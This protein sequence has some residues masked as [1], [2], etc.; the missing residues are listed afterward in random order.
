M[1]TIFSDSLSKELITQIIINEH[2]A[3]PKYE[4]M[5][6]ADKYLANENQEIESKTRDFYDK[7]GNAHNNPSAY[8]AKLSSG[9]LAELVKQKQDYALAKTFVLKIKKDDEELDIDNEYVRAWMDF[10]HKKL[11]SFAYILCGEAINH[12]IAWC[13][14]WIDEDG[15]L[16]LYN[17][18]G[19]IVFAVWQDRNHTKLDRLVYNYTTKTYKSLNP[20]IDEY[21]EYWDKDNRILFQVNDGYSEKSEIDADGNPIHSQMM[22]GNEP[23]SWGRIPFVALK[24]TDDEKPLLKNIKSFIDAYDQ[25]GSKAVDGLIDDTD[26]LLVF[27]GISPSVDDLIEARELAKMT[28]TISLDTDGDAYYIQAQTD[29][30]STL[31]E[32]QDLRRDIYKFGCG[33]DYEDLRF[34]GNP[35]QM[36]IKSL[37]QSLDTYIDGLE[38]HFQNFIDNLKYFFDKWLEWSNKGNFEEMNSCNVL[39]KFDR[40]VVINR[41]EMINDTVKLAG[42]GVS[43]KTLMEF[44]PVVQDVE[45]E[46]DRVE[47]ERKA[48]SEN[49]LFNFMQKTENEHNLEEEE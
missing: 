33:V 3:D 23:I 9:F 42:T 11:F 38:R 7:D 27:K 39:I 20:I 17:A 34:G 32:K 1:N 16:Q 22:L 25:L 30:D 46:L 40:S 44:N 6:I 8:N 26:P 31:K 45:M 48:N 12:G 37:Y 36:V 4:T 24:S 10:V 19:D 15:D 41:S 14:I 47:E 35:N 2:K 5:R 21:A 18:Q 49:D 28:R 43:Q 13:Y 29:V